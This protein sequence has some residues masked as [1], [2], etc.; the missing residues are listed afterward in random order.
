MT[1]P[2]SAELF[3]A[4][5]VQVTNRVLVTIGRRTIDAVPDSGASLSFIS[6]ALAN[7][8]TMGEVQA[9]FKDSC[10][11]ARLADGRVLRSI[12]VLTLALRVGPVVA[13][14][15]FGILPGLP[16]DA[17]LGYDLMACHGIVVD[18]RSHCLRF[19]D[20]PG[21]VLEYAIPE[22]STSALAG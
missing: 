10:R 12:K 21:A 6:E 19:T 18:P 15:D 20:F 16:C 9:Q 7:K 2:D 4:G 17:L 22:G 11:S 14:H 1:S 3:E 5:Q 13:N 8:L